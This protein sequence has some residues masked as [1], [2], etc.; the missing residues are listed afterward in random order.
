MA[1]P[2]K[3]ARAAADRAWGTY[4]DV[5]GMKEEARRFVQKAAPLYAALTHSS[6]RNVDRVCSLLEHMDRLRHRVL[7]QAQSLTLA[8]MRSTPQTALSGLREQYGDVATAL[9]MAKD[10]VNVLIEGIP[11]RSAYAAT[12]ESEEELLDH[13]ERCCKFGNCTF[14]LGLI[15]ELYRGL[16]GAE[17]LRKRAEVVSEV[18]GRE[19]IGYGLPA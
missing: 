7:H 6:W 2:C 18:L 12:P 16:P 8:E 1:P 4:V 3:R 14:A 10:K 19:E 11:M 13:Y 15:S 17:E 5:I 9:G